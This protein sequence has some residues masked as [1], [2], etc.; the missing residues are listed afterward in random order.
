M[1]TL[2]A[3]ALVA[4][5]CG[6]DADTTTEPTG[7][8]PPTTDPSNPDP[9]NTDPSNTVPATP[10]TAS[11]ELDP[12]DLADAPVDALAAG[13]NEAGFALLRTQPEADNLVFSPASIGHAL[14]MARGAADE[15]TGAAID[16]A[17]L[18]FTRYSSLLLFT[19]HDAAT[20]RR[21]AA[22]SSST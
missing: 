10:I 16:A 22:D 6:D 8:D 15:A 2:L 3:L 20:R 1:A 18:I 12:P 13:F 4:G 7:T 9:P 17:F 5:A 19:R 11:D 21:I 14:L